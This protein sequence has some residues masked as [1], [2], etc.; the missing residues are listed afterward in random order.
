[1]HVRARAMSVGGKG[2]RAVALC[3]GGGEGARRG[4]RGA[5]GVRAA[6]G[7]ARGAAA[8]LEEAGLV[9]GDAEGEEALALG[10]AGR[11]VLLND[12]LDHVARDAQVVPRQPREEVVLHLR[13]R[14]GRGE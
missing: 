8:R 10:R 6:R 1:M 11:E 4:Q 12:L 7:P 3:R 13:R 14:G 5:R 9:V 2:E